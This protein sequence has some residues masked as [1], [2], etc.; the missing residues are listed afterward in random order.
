ME[1]GELVALVL[2]EPVLRASRLEL[3]TVWARR[4]VH[5]WKVAL[6]DS[7]LDRDEPARLVRGLS[8]GML[9]ERS[10]NGGGDVQWVAAPEQNST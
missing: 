6:G 8:P 5:A 1:D 10:S 4:A 9:L 2:E 3:E 7:I